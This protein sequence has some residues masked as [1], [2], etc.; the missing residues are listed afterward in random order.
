MTSIDLLIVLGASL[1]QWSIQPT[2]HERMHPSSLAQPSCRIP[3]TPLRDGLEGFGFSKCS[4][5][6]WSWSRKRSINTTLVLILQT[7]YAKFV[8]QE[9]LHFYSFEF[10]VQLFQHESKATA[11][12]THANI[13][14]IWLS[15]PMNVGVAQEY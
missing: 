1:A 7:I 11:G 13:F 5:Y 6:G 8:S 10:Q 14:H 4:T 9:K 2:K 3:N 12:L 15:H